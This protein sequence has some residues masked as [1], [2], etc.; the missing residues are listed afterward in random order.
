MRIDYLGVSLIRLCEE[1]I[2]EVRLWRNA[3]HVRM[4]MEYQVLIS[5]EAQRKWFHS[6][7][8]IQ[9]FHFIIQIGHQRIGMVSAARINWNTRTGDAGIFIGEQSYLGSPHAVF[10]VLA[11]MDFMFEVMGIERLEAKVNRLNRPAVFFNQKLGYQAKE[12]TSQ[13]LFQEYY[14]TKATYF[15]R[16]KALRRAAQQLYGDCMKIQYRKGIWNRLDQCLAAV[17]TEM[18]TVQCKT[19]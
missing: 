9:H 8:N 12:P 15:Q 17:H 16:A 7:N 13:S 5:Q 11:M 10:A 14:V 19:Y 18:Y 3:E 4:N 6:I 1:D 2:E